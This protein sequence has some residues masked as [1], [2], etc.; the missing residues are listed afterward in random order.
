MTKPAKV[1][2]QGKLDYRFCH[3]ASEIRP[4]DDLKNERMYERCQNSF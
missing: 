3:D 2:F 4:V 1:V